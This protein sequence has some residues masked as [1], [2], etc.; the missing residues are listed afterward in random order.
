MTRWAVAGVMLLA[1]AM[2]LPSPP[3]LADTTAQAVLNLAIAGAHGVDY[4]GTQQVTVRGQHGIETGT[5]QVARAGKKMMMEGSGWVVVQDGR[6]RSS[7]GLNGGSASVSEAQLTDNIEPS[8]NVAQLLQKYSVDL[9]GAVQMLQRPAWVLRI[10]RSS[11]LRLIER[12]TVDAATGL[13]LQRQSFDGQGRI[14]RSITFTSVQEPYTP[15]DSALNPPLKGT[16]PAQQF[17]PAGEVTGFAHSAG[18][19]ETL[20][21]GYRLRAGARFSA[22]RTQVN[23]LV[24]SDGLE[25]VSLFQQPGALSRS[26]IPAGAQKVRLDHESGYLWQVFPRGAAWQAGPNTDTLVGASPSDEFQAIANALPQA[27]IGRSLHSRLH[28]LVDWVQ[29]RLPL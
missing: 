27:P 25:V 12:W 20:P 15:P 7:M 6:H 1:L 13:I 16:T 5:L 22:G 14:E 10:E 28:H 29:D 23:Q 19:P 26:S 8:G 21:G 24:Y 9:D 17:F 11:D 4:Q 18:L 3:A 2:V